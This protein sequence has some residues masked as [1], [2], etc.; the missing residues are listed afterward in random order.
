MSYKSRIIRGKETIKRN[1]FR[2][3]IQKSESSRAGAEF[4]TQARED[5]KKEQ[6]ANC[7]LD[8]FSESILGCF[9]SI[10]YTAMNVYV[11]VYTY[12][13]FCSSLFLDGPVRFIVSL[14]RESP[15][16]ALYCG[17]FLL[18]RFVAIYSKRKKIKCILLGMLLFLIK[19]ASCVV[20][21]RQRLFLLENF[22][23]YTSISNYKP[24]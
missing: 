9:G 23:S 21:M 10:L 3:L 12:T 8:R 4:Q 24:K 13:L 11:C 6:R 1:E 17:L 18:A 2:K 22:P 7:S 16:R 19:G 15:Y 5:E 14:S 20:N